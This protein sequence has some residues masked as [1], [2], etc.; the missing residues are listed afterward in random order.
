M[1]AVFHVGSGKTGGSCGYILD[2]EDTWMVVSTLLLSPP[3]ELTC[4]T[5]LL[6][7]Q[8]L[9]LNPSVCSASLAASHSAVHTAPA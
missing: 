2:L 5:L 9:V 3:C 6:Y 7:L 8:L 1:R 4:D